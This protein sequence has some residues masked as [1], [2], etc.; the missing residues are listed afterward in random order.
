MKK[1]LFSLLL[2][3]TGFSAFSKDQEGKWLIK[4]M[5]IQWGYNTEWYSKS[6]I[7]FRLGNGD[8]F[9]LHNAK[10][11]DKPDMQAIVNSPLDITIPQY[12]YRI[13]FYLNSKKTKAI[14]INFDHAKYVVTDY[15]RVKVTGTINGEEVDEFK[16]MDPQTFLHFEHTDG[17]NWFHFNYVSLNDL[18]FSKKKIRPVFTYLWKA[19]AGFNIPRSDFSYRGDRLNNN[20]HVAGYNFGAEGGLRYYPF[21]GVFLEGTGKI[22]YVRYMNALVDTKEMKGNRASHGF[23]Y[24]ELIATLG[25]DIKF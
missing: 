24:F 25:F 5:Y 3:F 21:K 20:F 13:G 6:N 4:G 15:Q 9:V 8:N 10:A 14:E 12:N 1:Y 22:G 23:G 2:I 17:A 18:Y 7:H 16:I 11:H 19:G